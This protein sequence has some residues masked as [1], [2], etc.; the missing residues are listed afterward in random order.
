MEILK[1]DSVQ[2]T[3]DG[4]PVAEDI[5]FSL[6]E[7]EI[8]GV[9]GES[10]SG[11]STIIKAVVGLLNSGGAV[12]NGTIR[13]K[14]ENLLEKSERQLR[15]IRGKEIGMIS[16]NASTTFCPIRKVG[17]QIYETLRA[18]GKISKREAKTKTLDI[19]N[20]LNFMDGEK[21]WNSYPFQLSGGMNQRVAVA[22][23]MLLEPK[24]LLSDEATSAL[25]NISR[26]Q[27]IS[28]LIK[29]YD[30]GTSV[31]FVTHDIDIVES[32]CDK[33]LVLK[34]GRMQ[35]YGSA[36]QVLFNPQNQYTKHLIQCTRQLRG[37]GYGKAAGNE[38]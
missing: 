23:A 5:S 25:D 38:V 34:D 4:I 33:V 11:K 18:H 9:V 6:N 31:I 21:V 19:F 36:K 26:N 24:I 14:G 29:L 17:D 28:E 15:Q 3:Y 20:K 1:L 32:I 22:L 7:G 30:M 27:V 37:T 2:I 12:K 35:E 16:Q 13:Y 10:G 8:L